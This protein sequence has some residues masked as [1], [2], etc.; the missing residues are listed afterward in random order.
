MNI[1]WQFVISDQVLLKITKTGKICCQ[2]WCQK[3]FPGTWAQREKYSWAKG[4]RKLDHPDIEHMHIK[5]RLRRKDVYVVD[6]PFCCSSHLHPRIRV[7][8]MRDN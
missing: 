5:K 2:T 7:R 6:I 4:T 1:L 8:T 3:R